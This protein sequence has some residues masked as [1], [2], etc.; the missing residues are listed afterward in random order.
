LEF[1]RILV[2]ASSVSDDVKHKYIIIEFWAFLL[3]PLIYVAAWV[4]Q[5]S[6]LSCP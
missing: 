5:F 4:L 6:K 3:S 2:L 1:A